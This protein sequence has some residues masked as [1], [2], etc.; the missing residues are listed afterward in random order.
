MILWSLAARYGGHDERPGVFH[1]F[2]EDGKRVPALK[3]LGGEKT[4]P[5]F[6]QQLIGL[7]SN[8]VDKIAGGAIPAN[9]NQSLPFPTSKSQRHSMKI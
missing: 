4:T 3:N 6:F 9:R 7:R 5:A 1:D 8:V 2:P